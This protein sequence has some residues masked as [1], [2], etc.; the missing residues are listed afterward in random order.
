VRGSDQYVKIQRKVISDFAG[1]QVA[2]A[3]PL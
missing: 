3:P 2:F 1:K